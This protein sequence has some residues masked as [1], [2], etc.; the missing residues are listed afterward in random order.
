MTFTEAEIEY[1]GTQR[2]GRLATGL[3][4]GPPG[5]ALVTA[6]VGTMAW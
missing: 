3:H 5:R 1:L 6:D 4:S 2:L